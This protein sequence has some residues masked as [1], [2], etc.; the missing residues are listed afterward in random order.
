MDPRKIPPPPSKEPNMWLLK[1]MQAPVPPPGKPR[2]YDG[3]ATDSKYAFKYLMGMIYVLDDM[4]KEEAYRDIQRIYLTE[5]MD[6]SGRYGAPF[7]DEKYVMWMLGV[8]NEYLL[9]SEEPGETRRKKIMNEIAEKLQN[10]WL[11]LKGLG[12][13]RRK[14]TRKTTRA[15]TRTKA[16]KTRTKARTKAR[17]RARV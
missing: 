6:L 4:R 12:G 8:T 3:N 16:R 17:T 7:N 5:W 11:S 9:I 10:K 14:N 15:R 1:L 2:E 13:G